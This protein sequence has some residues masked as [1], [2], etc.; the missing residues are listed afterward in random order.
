[1]KLNCFLICDD[2]RNELGNKQSLTGIYDDVINFSM[3][4]IGKWPK[5]VK[6][7]IYEP[8]TNPMVFPQALGKSGI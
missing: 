2:I 4:D 5:V 7:G 8:I 1:M 3:K 6:L